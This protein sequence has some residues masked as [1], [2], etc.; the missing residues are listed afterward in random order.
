MAALMDAVMHTAAGPGKGE[1]VRRGGGELGAGRREG[2][3]GGCAAGRGDA[4]CS[5]ATHT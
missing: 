5:R 3:P 1:G 4:H 2:G